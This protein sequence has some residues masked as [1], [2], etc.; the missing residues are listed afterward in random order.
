MS[1]VCEVIAGDECQYENVQIFNEPLLIHLVNKS[2][3]QGEIDVNLRGFNSEVTEEYAKIPFYLTRDGLEIF[4]N[5]PQ[6][7]LPYSDAAILISNY[8]NPQKKNN[9]RISTS[10]PISVKVT[11]KELLAVY[12]LASILHLGNLKNELLKGFPRLN[13]YEASHVLK[14][15]ASVNDGKHHFVDISSLV[16]ERLSPCL[17]QIPM[18]S[19]KGI[20]IAP[21]LNI[22]LEKA[23]INQG[24]PTCIIEWL[25]SSLIDWV[26]AKEKDLE[27]LKGIIQRLPMSTEQGTFIC[28]VYQQIFPEIETNADISKYSDIMIIKRYEPLMNVSSKSL[29]ELLKCINPVLN[30]MYIM[31]LVCKYTIPENMRPHEDKL[32]LLTFAC[33]KNLIHIEKLEGSYLSMLIPFVWEQKNTLMLKQITVVINQNENLAKWKNAIGYRNKLLNNVPWDVLVNIFDLQRN[34]K[35]TVV[36]LTVEETKRQ[37]R[38]RRQEMHNEYISVDDIFYKWIQHNLNIVQG[39]QLEHYMKMPSSIVSRQKF[40]YRSWMILNAAYYAQHL[41]VAN[42]ILSFINKDDPADIL[43]RLI[44]KEEAQIHF[45]MLKYLHF[46]CCADEYLMDLFVQFLLHQK[47]YNIEFYLPMN[48]ITVERIIPHLKDFQGLLPLHYKFL[49][50]ELGKVL[51]ILPRDIQKLAA[52]YISPIQLFDRSF[53]TVFPNEEEALFLSIINGEINNPSIIISRISI[54]SALYY[55]KIPSKVIKLQ[56]DSEPNELEKALQEAPNEYDFISDW[57][58]IK[59]PRSDFIYGMTNYIPKRVLIICMTSTSDPLKAD[60]L[61][62]INQCL[63][64]MNITEAESSIIFEGDTFQFAIPNLIIIWKPI[65]AIESSVAFI[66]HI[67]DILRKY[68]SALVMMQA[69]ALKEFILTSGNE[70]YNSFQKGVWFDFSESKVDQNSV[71]H[72]ISNG[73]PRSIEQNFV[74]YPIGK[75][76]N[77]FNAIGFRAC[78]DKVRLERPYASVE[79]E[80]SRQ[81]SAI[82]KDYRIGYFNFDIGFMRF[83]SPTP[84]EAVR[85]RQVAELLYITISSLSQCNFLI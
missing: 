79:W 13:F 2:G 26:R 29:I 50:A 16:I 9:E 67:L 24:D 38:I 45:E 74:E 64:F 82:F 18:N 6:A 15:I 22:M 54:R 53:C 85:S 80:G 55:F 31:W 23:N 71:S 7:D 4:V 35:H 62:G 30:E 51:W 14:Q 68:P 84:I 61:I 37:M 58:D 33:E 46:R 69:N 70:W 72:W 19:F 56:N 73:F 3:E 81:L 83:H 78:M 44:T 5:V 43:K 12:I 17:Y 42:E 49:S 57:G 20:E 8:I 25:Y 48:E 1:I 27:S 36:K 28:W 41:G 77:L 47:Y 11:A 59:L 10:P 21:A 60:Y 76:V 75:E 32:E 40:P 52:Q 66:A 34:L 39:Y 63:A 65:K